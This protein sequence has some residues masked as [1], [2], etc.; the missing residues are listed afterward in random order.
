MNKY[1]E[2]LKKINISAKQS[3]LL[4]LLS[5][6]LSS[7]AEAANWYVRPNG[8]TYG[9]STGKDW[10]NAKSGFSAITWSAVA[11][12]DTIWVAGGTYTQSLQPNRK[13]SSSTR[14]SIRRARSDAP[15]AT[16]VAGWTSGFDSSVH[17]TNGAGIT[18]GGDWDYITVSGRTTSAGGNLGWW[19][20]MTGR[21]SGTGITFDNGAG[22]DYNILEYMDVQ[23]PG[24][25]TYSGDGRGIDATPFSSATGNVFSHLNIH[26]W[27]SAIYH[28]GI[29]GSTFEYLDVYDIMAQN[30]SAYHPNGLYAVDSKNVVVRYS[31]FHKGPKGNGTGEG[32]FFEQSGGNSNWTIYGNFFYNLDQS[33]TKAIEIT[34][35]SDNIK[36]INNTFYNVGS[37]MYMQASCGAGSQTSNNLFFKASPSTCGT[38]SNNLTVSSSA[39]FANPTSND[40]HIISTIG[41]GYPRNAGTSLSSYIQNDVDGNTFGSDGTWD[42]GADEFG[43][44]TTTQSITPPTGLTANP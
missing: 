39:V 28:A 30:W 41:A 11:C 8:S 20:D 19:I 31:K 24:A 22:A 2:Q 32:I 23:G 9:A 35:N 36:I 44:S 1:Y 26:D 12:G 4:F 7:G 40:F 5:C 38:M 29:H 37:A 10:T 15:E 14:L 21:T 16:S 3:V 17:Q 27:E 42:V 43:G 33:G 18:F 25:V 13:C 34:S 6:A